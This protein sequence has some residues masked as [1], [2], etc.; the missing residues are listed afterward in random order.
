MKIEV[1]TLFPELV[2][3]VAEWGVV[4][5]AARAGTLC[6]QST[7]LRDFADDSHRT[8]DD[9]PY[10]G[11]PGMVMKPE[12][13]CAAI[14]DARARLVGAEVIYLSPQGQR[15]DQTLAQ[16]LATRRELVL[17]AG[18]YEGVDE[19]VIRSHVDRELSIG[20]FVLSGGELGAMVIIDAVA[21]LLDGVLGH[22]QSAEQDSFT[23]GLLDY[24]HFTRPE[25]FNGIEVPAVLRSGD[26]RAIAQWRR[27][28]ALARTKARRP[29]L[30]G[31][32]AL[33]KEDRQLLEQW[34]QQCGIQ[35]E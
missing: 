28:Q 30:F 29:D 6:V 5:R 3:G 22:N 10:G 25:S 20:D 2:Q 19:R 27:Q 23:D 15:F 8:V 4:G 7:N 34:E 12:P 9:R 17:L 21:R 16:E 35:E 18:R 31:R 33:S 14:D 32:L 13:L 1:L 24:P 11:G 26:H